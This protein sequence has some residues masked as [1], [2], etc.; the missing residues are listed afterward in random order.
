MNEALSPL[1]GIIN[2]PIS[3]LLIQSKRY[4]KH[5]R[6]WYEEGNIGFLVGDT[7]FR[8]HRSVLSRCSSVISD[9]SR[10]PQP[11]FAISESFNSED[12]IIGVPFVELQGQAEDFAHVLDFIYPNS[13]PTAR[14]GH[15]GVNDLM[16]LVRFTGTYL[17]EDLKEWAISTL[18][19]QL[20]TSGRSSFKSLLQNRS[21]YA[22]P[23]FCVKIVKFSRECSLPKFLP[24]AFYG[25]STAEWDQI[26]GGA[27]CLDQL[28]PEDRTRVHEGR[29]ALSKAILEQTPSLFENIS[30][31]ERCTQNGCNPTKSQEPGTPWK[32][33]ILHPLEELESLDSRRTSWWK[34]LRGSTLCEDCR[35]G[36]TQIQTA[37]GELMGRLPELFKLESKVA[38]ANQIIGSD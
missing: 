33:L 13:L 12:N 7:A 34:G 21:L 9:M 3:T 22:D 16:G 25:L 5:G 38:E 2:P 35:K 4:K 19:T 10:T 17:I 20:L 14:T 24:L 36:A 23:N 1:D 26:P 18:G 6:H 29:L 28:S 27:A 11:L 32:G 8:L 30:A 15:L 37:R 31:R